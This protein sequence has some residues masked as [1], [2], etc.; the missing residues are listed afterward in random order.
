MWAFLKN[1]KIRYLLIVLGIVG[2]VVLGF[3]TLIL[4]NERSQNWLVKQALGRVLANQA[5]RA[6]SYG[7]D[8]LDIVFCGTASPMGNTRRAQQCIAILA[9][10]KFFIIDSGARST[11]KASAA[12][13]PLGRLDG[14][15]LT[16]FHSDHI[17][18]LGELHLASW[19]QGRGQK[20]PV[21]GGAGVA[22]IVDGFN[23]AYGPDYSYRTAHHGEAIMPSRVAGLVA[24]HF[25]VPKR[26]TS[27]IYQTDD[28]SIS[29]FKVPHEPVRPAIGYRIDY[30]DRSVVISGDT[31]KSEAVILASA[32]AD[33]LIHEVLQPE[34]VRMTSEVLKANNNAP[35]AQLVT[36]TLTYHTSPVEAADVANRAN[37]DMLVFTHF[38]PAPANELIENIFLRGVEDVR[39]QGAVLADDGLYIR[40]PIG[41]DDIIIMDE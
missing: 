17:A 26:G 19:V 5:Q 34:L 40:L 14:V 30:K 9:G 6:A 39:P 3:R 18:S 1:K 12:A 2:L 33:V 11:A 7:G 24:H 41:T 15:L 21:Y 25:A 36:D 29:A 13:L 35:L 23:M 28:L 37:V 31:S 22:R 27:I 4:T 20:L 10:D 32:D 8:N 38:A 16:H